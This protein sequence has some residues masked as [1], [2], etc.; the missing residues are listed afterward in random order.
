MLEA[1]KSDSGIDFTELRVDGGASV[2][3][4]ML[5]IQADM[6]R[7]SVNRP[8][9]V[10]TTALGAAYLAGLAVGL[11]ESTAEIQNNRKVERV[12]EPEMDEARRN[13]IYAG[14]KRAI[15]CSKGWAK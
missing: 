13:E 2:S 15:E 12:F 6:I 8:A 4:I 7:C 1:M 5:Q 11:W 3:N 14:W 9:N 10:E